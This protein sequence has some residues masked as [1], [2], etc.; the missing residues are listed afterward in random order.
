MEKVQEKSLE[1]ARCEDLEL[2]L[3]VAPHTYSLSAV[4]S[5]VVWYLQSKLKL[6]HVTKAMEAGAPR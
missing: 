4:I 1:K 3:P 2:I 5:D 6:A